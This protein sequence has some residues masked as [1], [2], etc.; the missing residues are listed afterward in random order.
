MD[1]DSNIL[2]TADELNKALGYQEEPIL[3]VSREL[4]DRWRGEADDRPR[5]DNG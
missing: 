2:I 3:I 4:Y 1:N 5:T